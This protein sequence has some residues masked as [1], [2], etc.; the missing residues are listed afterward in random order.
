LGT[1]GP[2]GPKLPAS[3]KASGDFVRRHLWLQKCPKLVVIGEHIPN[4]KEHIHISSYLLVMLVVEEKAQERKLILKNNM[5]MWN[6][7]C[8]WKAFSGKHW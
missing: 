8:C 6:Q 7:H 4:L 2:A 5:P 3:A 1:G